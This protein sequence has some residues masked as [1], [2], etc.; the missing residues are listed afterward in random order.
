MNRYIYSILVVFL[1]LL[2]SVVVQTE[3]PLINNEE[4]IKGQSVADTHNSAQHRIVAAYGKVPL[5]FEANQGQTDEK[6]K[7]LS[8]GKGYTLF[9]T[10]TEAVLALRKPAETLPNLKEVSSSATTEPERFEPTTATVLR[11][12][13]LGANPEPKVRG[14]DKLAG[15]SNY[16]VGNDPEKWRTNVPHYSKVSFEEVYPGIDLVYYGTNQRQLE[17]DFIV[18]PGANPKTIQLK[19]EGADRLE[20]DAQGDLLLRLPDGE[21]RFHKP[22]VYQESNATRQEIAASYVLKD[23]NEVVFEVAAYDSSLPLIIDPV[24]SYSDLTEI[25]YQFQ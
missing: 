3:R 1:C 16:F 10:S 25:L 11:M 12:K 24:L 8:R 6:V 14:G 7:F 9:L 21:V 19:F 18:A 20:V 15:R 23:N 17:H 5:S 13:F 4:V 22:H 2:A